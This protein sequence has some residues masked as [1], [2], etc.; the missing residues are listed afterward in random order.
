M[1]GRLS[2][3]EVLLESLREKDPGQVSVLGRLGVLFARLGAASR[4]ESLIRSLEST[5]GPY[6]FGVVDYWRA[7]AAAWGGQEEEALSRLH[8]AISDGYR[9]GIT[10]HADPFLEPL[11]PLPAFSMAVSEES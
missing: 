2:E 5:R 8:R 1:D 11:W 3:A 10:L 7:A 9:R 4:L 6:D